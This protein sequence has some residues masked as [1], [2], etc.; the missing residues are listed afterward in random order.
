MGIVNY[1]PCG[2][3]YGGVTFN[4]WLKSLGYRII[5]CSAG[6]GIVVGVML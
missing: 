4:Y 6:F 3:L 1:W 5:G 2:N